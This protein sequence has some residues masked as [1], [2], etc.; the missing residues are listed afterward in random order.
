MPISTTS[1]LCINCTVR[2]N[3]TQITCDS[4]LALLLQGRIN[5]TLSMEGEDL[6][7]NFHEFDP[8]DFFSSKKFYPL[9]DSISKWCPHSDGQAETTLIYST[10]WRTTALC[11]ASILSC[12]IPSCLKWVELGSE[13][14]G[15]HRAQFALS[16]MV[17]NRSGVRI[18]FLIVDEMTT[19]LD[20]TTKVMS[21]LPKR[22]HN[23]EKPND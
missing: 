16:E 18:P 12:K 10:L 9:P 11:R 15:L 4:F 2:Q 19:H 20:P 13:T 17:F 7:I 22:A 23:L 3:L 1:F 21:L 14:L 6:Q 8:G 5:C